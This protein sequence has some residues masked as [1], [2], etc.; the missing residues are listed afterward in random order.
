MNRSRKLSLLIASVVMASVFTV[1]CDSGTQEPAAP[2]TSTPLQGDAAD[3]QSEASAVPTELPEGFTAEI[4]EEFPNELPIYPGSAPAQG[5]GAVSDGVPMAA[6]QFQ[7][8]DSPTQ[9][10]DFYV[11]KLSNDGWTI[12]EREGFADKNAVSATNGE[13]TATVLAAPNRDGTT[14]IFVLTE[15]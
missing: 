4:P 9:V 6:V 11:D 7:T 14:S 2:D 10:Y 3:T 8:S 15:C 1:A 13:C 12:E 5:K